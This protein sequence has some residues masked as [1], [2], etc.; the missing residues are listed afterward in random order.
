MFHMLLWMTKLP[1]EYIAPFDEDRQA[2]LLQTV[3]GGGVVAVC[4]G[5][6]VVDADGLDDAVAE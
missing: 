4:V 5:V 6:A 1:S 3:P 2:G